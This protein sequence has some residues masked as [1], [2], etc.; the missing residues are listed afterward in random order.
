[1]NTFEYFLLY[2]IL[3]DLDNGSSVEEL[4]DRVLRLGSENLNFSTVRRLSF[5]E[6]E[7]NEVNFKERKPFFESYK[8]GMLAMDGKKVYF[9]GIIDLFTNYG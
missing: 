1:M 7:F 6:N 4:K 2:F 8:G 3:L 9:F 5:G